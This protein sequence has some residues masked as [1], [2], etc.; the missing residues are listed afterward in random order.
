MCSSSKK[1]RESEVK[2]ETGDPLSDTVDNGALSF[3]IHVVKK[4]KRRKGEEAL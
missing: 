4:A 1:R 2:R 3:D